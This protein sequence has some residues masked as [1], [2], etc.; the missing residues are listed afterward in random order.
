LREA[1]WFPARPS[2]ERDAEA[3]AVLAAVGLSA[4]IDSLE[5][6]AHWEQGLSLGEQQRLAIA[7]ALLIKPDWLFLDEATSATDEE[8]EAALYRT[9]AD[10]LPENDGD[11]RRAS[12]LA[13][14]LSPTGDRGRP[15]R[16]S[17]TAHRS[18]SRSCRS[19]RSDA[20]EVRR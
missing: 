17:R 2:M 6:D 5:E 3:R 20:K 18:G 14:G 19:I 13:G 16:T 7:R 8:E 4:L 15:S 9:I 1:L 10:S 12:R 11:Q